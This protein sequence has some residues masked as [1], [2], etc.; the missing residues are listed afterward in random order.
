MISTTNKEALPSY[1]SI[2][3]V[4]SEGDLRLLA[5]ESKI[6]STE[7]QTSKG[8]TNTVSRPCQF[9]DNPSLKLKYDEVPS[10]STEF[11]KLDISLSNP[12]FGLGK[13]TY[14]TS[15]LKSFQSK[16][17][18]TGKTNNQFTENPVFDLHDVA[19]SSTSRGSSCC[20][21]LR[22]SKQKESC[23]TAFC[24]KGKSATRSLIPAVVSKLAT[25]SKRG[26]QEISVKESNPAKLKFR[27]DAFIHGQRMNKSPRIRLHPLN[28]A[29]EE[30]HHHTA[31]KG[32][33][34]GRSDQAKKNSSSNLDS[35]RS[36]RASISSSSSIEI[37]VN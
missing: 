23:S 36:E 11:S 35:E 32:K 24:R 18:E 10:P 5:S 19:C 12:C 26:A 8:V 29:D 2:Y 15:I 13:E 28:E 7:N 27:F 6:S 33:E 25:A 9:L 37:T 17:E 1:A 30:H 3:P 22:D 20:K 14:P 16:E 31:F 34:A 21:K 4:L